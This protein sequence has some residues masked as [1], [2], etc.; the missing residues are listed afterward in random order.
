MLG[1]RGGLKVHFIYTRA[2]SMRS[3][4]FLHIVPKWL[5]IAPAF[6]TRC[7]AVERRLC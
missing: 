5:P 3:V 6:L 2:Q 7:D 4:W 1:Q